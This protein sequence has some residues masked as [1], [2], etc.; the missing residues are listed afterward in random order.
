MAS[1]YGD[2]SVKK[3]KLELIRRGASLRGRKEDLVER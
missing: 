1:K 3:L 2:I